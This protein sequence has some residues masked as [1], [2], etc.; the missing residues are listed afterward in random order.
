MAPTASSNLR[1]PLVERGGLEKFIKSGKTLA[2][3]ISPRDDSI[4]VYATTLTHS[5]SPGSSEEHPIYTTSPHLAPS[6]ERRTFVTD[7]S[8]IFA[9]VRNL[10]QVAREEGVQLSD[11]VD[12]MKAMTKLALDYVNHCKECCIY[13]AQETTRHEPLQ[14]DA[15]HYRKLYTCFSLFTVLYMPESGL[16]DA[17]VGDEVMDWLNTHYIE[18]STEDGDNLS[19]LDRP[20]EDE[21]F[22]PYLTRAT[23]RGLTKASAFFL[24]V[25]SQHPS[26]D[27]QRLSQLLIPL[28]TNHP[29]LH[30]FAAERDFAVA[31]RRWKDKVKSLRLEL[32]RV[33]EEDREDGFE[34]WWER[35]SDIV[36]I[37]EGRG[38]N[39]KRIVSEL[40]GDWKEVCAVW[41]VFI[42]PRIR[43][44]DLPDLIE[45]LLDEL[46][47]DPTSLEDVIHSSLFLGR[48]SRTLTQ[49]AE[50]DIWL[51]A[52]LADIMEPLQLIEVE[53]DDSGHP[54]RDHYVLSYAEYLRSDPSLWRLTVDYMS[55][56]GDIGKAM[57]DQVLV[58]VPLRLRRHKGSQDAGED[59]AQIHS[60]QLA[61]VLKEVAET[62]FEYKREEVRRTICRIA[63]QTFMQ[64]K[65]FGL[66]VSY[67]ASAE[68]WSGLG[69]VVDR[70]LEEYIAEGPEPF[71]R[72]VANVA[73]VLHSLRSQ[74]SAHGIFLYRLMFAVRF[75]EFHQR[76]VNGD[77]QEAAFDLVAM[78]R[79]D[80]APRS[81]WGVLLS[82]AVELL[83]H[84]QGML[85]TNN[86]A[87]LFLHK[88][89]EIDTRCA[90]GGQED[91]LTVLARVMK[92]AGEKQILQRLQ[93]IRLV[94]ARYVARCGV[95]GVGGRSTQGIMY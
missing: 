38:E 12:G 10:V 36:S 32:D 65:E 53:P 48:P 46:P 29:R 41:G 15:D 5:R 34:N 76:R 11:T 69:H 19:S 1:P 20:W 85:F 26:P 57:A 44:S 90:Q 55:S 56:C 74:H 33:P 8:V 68:D 84:S 93:V 86:D 92:G 23:L 83:Q 91:Y 67:C 9:A 51:A 28:L 77:L 78:F 25:L 18:P 31:S 35:F 16:D 89:Q 66:A 13:A 17:P 60:G 27:L 62:C 81:W 70:V 88:L 45:D 54:L 37:L 52:H 14:F 82:D 39:V 87:V 79:E 61:G 95:I 80:L 72:L 30:Q 71:A 21:T 58:R 6:S 43:R 94:L 42:D 59:I 22:W 64:E 40:G 50:L 4:A 47:P 7:T 3:T 73:P 24:D 49:A 63:A 2:T 75:A